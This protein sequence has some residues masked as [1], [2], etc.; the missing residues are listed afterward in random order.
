MLEDAVDSPV[1]ID[2]AGDL[3]RGHRAL[4]RR[5]TRVAGGLTGGLAALGVGAVPVVQHLHQTATIQAAT[6]PSGPVHTA[7][8]D[9]PPPP[10]GWSLAASGGAFLT[11]ARD[12]VP[13]PYPELFAHK[14]GIALHPVDQPMGFGST[15]EYDG[16]TFY[17]NERNEGYPILAVQLDDGRWLTLQYPDSAGLEKSEMRAYLA[18]VSVKPAACVGFGC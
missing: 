12:G 17:D 15:L 8:F 2:V 7:A 16:R 3:R 6:D 4:R 5:R 18:G 1:T 10:A 11:L 14:I 9:A 13:D